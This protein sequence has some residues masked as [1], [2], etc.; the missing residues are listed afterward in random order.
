MRY[1]AIAALVALSA[2]IGNAQSLSLT[3]GTTNVALGTTP[4]EEANLDAAGL[5]VV[6]IG[7]AT[8][9][10]TILTDGVAFP[11]DPASSFLFTENSVLP[12]SGTIDHFGTVTVNQTGLENLDDVTL[13]DF[14]IGYDMDRAD[15]ATG[16]S[17]FFVQDT[18]SVNAPVFDL[19]NLRDIVATPSTLTVGADL[20]VSPELSQALARRG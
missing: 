10:S 4:E 1:C 5:T 12:A 9:E 20:L 15:S 3:G 14:S 8:E 2:S 16:A 11:I 13:G 6:D 19:G 7:G 17:G 18:V